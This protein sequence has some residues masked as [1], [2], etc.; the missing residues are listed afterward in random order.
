VVVDVDA[1]VILEPHVRMVLFTLITTLFIKKRVPSFLY[2][3]KLIHVTR[4]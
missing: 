1:A 3:A 2:V 4:T